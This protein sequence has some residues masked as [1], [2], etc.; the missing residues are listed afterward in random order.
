MYITLIYRKLYYENLAIL[1]NKVCCSSVVI[2]MLMALVPCIHC[3]VVA[4][5]FRTHPAVIS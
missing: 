5:H 1:A 2:E 4:F 3:L